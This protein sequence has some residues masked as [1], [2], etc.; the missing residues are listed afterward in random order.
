LIEKDFHSP[1]AYLTQLYFDIMTHDDALLAYLGERVGLATAVYSNG[2]IMGAFLG[3][4][5]TPA[6]LLLLGALT[7]RGLFAAW[8]LVALACGTTSIADVMA[9][10]ADEV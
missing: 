10:T 5:L 8:G 3:T 6:A 9:F 2:F 7:W 4:A 1:G